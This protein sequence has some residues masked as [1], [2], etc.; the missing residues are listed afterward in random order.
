MDKKPYFLFVCVH[1]AGRSQMAA[2]FMRELSREGIGAVR[3]IRD[4]IER[5]VEALLADLL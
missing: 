2:D 4:E 3:V 1:N 5:R